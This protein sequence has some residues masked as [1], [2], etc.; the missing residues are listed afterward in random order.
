MIIDNMVTNIN[1]YVRFYSVGFISFNLYNSIDTIII[2]SLQIQKLKTREQLNNLP[3]VTQQMV[4]KIFQLNGSD[5]FSL[6]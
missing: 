4:E 1:Y 3:K 6:K 2:T 5:S